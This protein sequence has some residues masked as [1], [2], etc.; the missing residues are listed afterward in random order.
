[1]NE[2]IDKLV[3]ALGWNAQRETVISKTLRTRQPAFVL[4]SRHGSVRAAH[5][6]RAKLRQRFGHLGLEFKVVNTEADFHTEW[7]G[8]IHVRFDP[9]HR[10]PAVAG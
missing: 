1:M 3:R 10:S 8:E 5:V 7:G 6:T 2:G 4:C 9:T